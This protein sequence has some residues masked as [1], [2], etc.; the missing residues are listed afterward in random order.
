MI[1]PDL[2]RVTGFVSG[3]WIAEVTREEVD[4]VWRRVATATVENRLGRAAKVSRTNARWRNI[5]VAMPG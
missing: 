3:K 2:A 4:D 5:N 1:C